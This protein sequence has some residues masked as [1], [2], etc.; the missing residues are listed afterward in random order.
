MTEREWREASDMRVSTLGIG[1]V[2]LTAAV[3]RF[4]GLGHGIPFAIGIDEPEIMERAV[5]MM[6][7]GDL[8]PHFFDYPSLYIYV[9][10][11][12]VVLRFLVGASAGLWHSLA[13]VGAADFYLWGRVV[14]AS[15]GTATVFLV[16]QIGMRWGT[17][18][19]L[20]A[21]GLM[22][23]LPNHVRESHFVL[24]DVPMTFFV[25]LAFLQALQAHERGK[26]STFLFA[27]VAAGLAA[28]TKY[29]GAVALLLP[30]MA[31]YMTRGLDRP[32]MRSALLAVG[33]FVLA[34]LVAAP[35]T[36]LD[37]PHFLDGYARLASDV[38]LDGRA[39]DPGWLI[40]LKHLRTGLG[41][42][43]LLL[44]FGGLGL[45]IVRIVTGPGQTRFAMVLVFLAVYFPLIAARTLI[46]ARYTL[47]M[48]PF[49][50]L[51]AAVAVVSGV[52]LLRRFDIPRWARTALIAAL[53]I[54]AL[55]PPAIGSIRFDRDASRKWT[56][57]YAYEW[58]LANVPAGHRIALEGVGLRL[59]E[60][61]FT[62]QHL[63]R[64]T[65]MDYEG[66]AAAGVEYVVA[67]SHYFGAPLEAP[68]QHPGDWAAYSKLFGKSELLAT[69]SPGPT[70]PGPELRIYRV[71]PL[72]DA[73]TR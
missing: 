68:N 20:L 56:Y 18:H 55:L 22:A 12:V 59:P 11:V 16:Y 58:L 6:K 50:C 15:L 39:S 8:N 53:T 35:Y 19:A 7:T 72:G 62:A 51:L 28:A 2:L 36:V 60:P 66:Y 38:S 48:L 70:V 64:L 65:Q 29:T 5:R 17:R 40:Y 32:R 54:A 73:G 25:T 30:L 41:W 63:R 43:A 1:S 44:A 49:V 13:D 45:F 46:F 42:P 14:T 23:L 31:A 71:A 4:W 37:L 9:Q 10:L 24:T 52:S 26:D 47:P 61:R 33:G 34:F 57:R 69:F 21:A 27:G 67:S 3:L